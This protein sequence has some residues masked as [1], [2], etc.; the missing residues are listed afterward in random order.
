MTQ[1]FRVAGGSCLDRSRPVSFTFDG[2]AYGGYE[3]DTLASA[4]IANGV[5]LVGRSYKYHRPRGILTAGS[6]EPNAL[7]GVS[8]GSGRFTP[9][10]RATEIELY[11]GLVATSQNRWPSLGF[12]VGGIND[13]ASPVF[14]A[15]FYYKTFMGPDLFGINWA[16]KTIYEPVIRFAAGLGAVPSEPDPDRY[17]RYFDHCDVLIVGAGPA[18]LA[19]ALAAGASGADVVLCD[20]NTSLGGS[21]LAEARASIDLKSARD[22]LTSALA[23]L[24]ES[25]NVRLMPRT[26]AF[27]YYAQNFLGLSERLAEPDLPDLPRERLWQMRAKEVVL[28]AGAIERPLVFADNDRPGIML[29]DA[30][31][32]YLN[33]YAAKV[34]ERVVVVTAHDDAYRA[35][36]D[37]EDA[38]VGVGL[39]ADL[40]DAVDGPLP[41][42]AREAG[43]P[44]AVK[45][46]VHAIEGKSR[47]RA[48][49]LAAHPGGMRRIECDALLTSGGWTPSVHLFSQSRGKL[50]FDEAQQAFK[51]A[52]SAQRERSAGACNGTFGLA[53]ALAEGDAAGRE[54]VAAAGFAAPAARTYEVEGALPA[55][56]GALGAPLQVL[57]NRKMKAFVD[58]QNDVCVKDIELAIQEGMRSIEHIKRYT[59]TGMATDQGKLSNMNALAIAA[60]IR[61]KPIAEVG[62]TTFRQ[63]YTPVSFGAFAGPARGALFDPVRKTPIHDGAAAKGAAFED[64]G[65]W[66][67]AWYFPREGESVQDAVARECRTTRAA[68][69]LFDASTLGKIEVV[70]PDAAVFLELMY[71]NAFRKLEVG[72]CRYGLM[73]TE[74]GFLMDDGVVARLASDRFHVTTTTGGAPRVLTHMEDYLQTEFPGL[75]VWL[76]S[77]TEQWAVIAVQGPKARETIAPLV[78]GFELINEAFP[79]MSVR[80][81]LVCGVPARLMRMSFTGELGYEVNVGSAYGR[82]VWEAAW[83][84]VEARGGCAYGTE[85]MH[86][87]RAEKG[88]VIVGQD[89]D[90]TATLG[91]LGLD[92]A[93]GKTKTDFVGKRSLSLPEMAKDDRKQLV[94]LLT[95]DPNV[96][97]EEGAQIT[98]SATPAPASRA[99]GHVTSAYRSETLGRSIA[100]ALVSAGRS[101]IGAKL[102][103]PMANGAIPVTVASPAFYDKEG[104]RLHG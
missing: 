71:A 46:A 24:R 58:Y 48:V 17:V 19:A 87:M 1:R 81:T 61:G 69:G 26:Q 90:G 35:A 30:A 25:A 97:L 7:V 79:H 41:A 8:R 80:E 78:E 38:G 73:L 12:D 5:R 50:A 31:R 53:E 70:G 28:A 84:E 67:R 89:T 72:R 60:A 98:E 21:L 102:H 20:E 32:R 85:A 99:L 11:D 64:V 75:Q 96:V 33:Q 40:R 23:V 34:G 45:A 52:G 2:V 74:T 4:L 44:V 82:E 22:W 15:G 88:Y 10:L 101:R 37:L 9:N 66:K 47:L 13:L 95:E 91:D 56:G 103:V 39:I 94:G 29:A 16:W 51:P 43:I 27:G 65:L 57:G 104:A 76:T 6:E 92:W 59:T 93:I 42:A 14:S 36:L 68:V 86:V 83:R 54:A 18:G 49:R 77:T 100:L 63:P 62:L 3:G 55:S